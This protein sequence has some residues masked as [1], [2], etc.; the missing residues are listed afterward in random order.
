[1]MVKKTEYKKISF[2]KISILISA[3]NEAAVIRKTVSS[4]LSSS[5]KNIELIVCA[6]N[7]SDDTVKIL[8]SIKHPNF[9][10]IIS[11]IGK[12]KGDGLNAAVKYA[13][14]ELVCVLDADTLI[15]KD[16][17]DVV[18]ANLSDNAAMQTEVRLYNANDSFLSKMGDLEFRIA[19]ATRQAPF[20][21]L[22]ISILGGSGM[23]VRTNVLEQIGFWGQSLAD[24]TEMSIKIMKLGYKIGYTDK[25]CIHQEGVTQLVPYLKQRTRWLQGNIQLIPA[26]FKLTGIAKWNM[27]LYMGN[28]ILVPFVMISNGIWLNNINFQIGINPE[29][30]IF[31]LPFIL[32]MAIG[33]VKSK[34]NILWLPIYYLYTNLMYVVFLMA[35]KRIIKHQN[36]WVKTVREGVVVS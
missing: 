32:T 6:H 13:T 28:A 23:F 4:I 26:I 3:H 30:I 36:N 21:K 17:F 9:K 34:I 5:Y 2:I 1:M 15:P 18:L 31:T 35:C 27:L 16:Y 19:W 25:T 33:L 22:G 11:N 14:G 12:T 7:C 29:L 20:A 10:Y 8:E 24:D